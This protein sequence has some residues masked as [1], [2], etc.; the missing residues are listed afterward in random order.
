MPKQNLTDDEFIEQM[1][2]GESPV[3]P[4]PTRSEQALRAYMEAANPRVSVRQEPLGPG[5]VGA[6]RS[7]SPDEI[8]LSSKMKQGPGKTEEVLLHEMEHSLS[9]RGGNPLGAASKFTSAPVTTDNN[10]RFDLLYNMGDKKIENPSVKDIRRISEAGEG[11]KKRLTMI[12]NFVNN[13]RSLEQ[14][15][16]RPID[17]AYFNPN[18]LKAQVRYGTEGALFAEQIAD[19]SA[20]EQLT[21][22]SLTRDKEMKKLLFPDDRSAQIYDA[23]TG[24]RQTRLDSKD[25]P[26]YTPVSPEEPGML[27]RLKSLFGMQEGGEVSNEDFI[28]QMTVGTR[29][30]D[31]EADPNVVKDIVR[32]VQYTPFDVLG[33]PVDIAT[34]VMRP[35]GYNVEKPFGGSDYFIEQAAKRGLVQPATGSGAELL[36]RIA[37]GVTTPAVARG[38]GKVAEKTEDFVSKQLGAAAEKVEERSLAKLREQTGNPN[39]SAK[40]V[41]DAMFAAQAPGVPVVKPKGGNVIMENID[42]VDGRPVRSSPIEKMRPTVTV[43]GDRKPEILFASEFAARLKEQIARNQQDG[44]PTGYMRRLLDE[45]EPKAALDNWIQTKMSKYIRTDMGSE[46]DP[47]RKLAEEMSTKVKADYEA[48][49]KRIGKMKD[50]IAKA[51]AAGKNTDASEAELAEEIDKVENAYRQTS[52]LPVSIGPYTHPSS[53]N[54]RARAKAGFPEEPISKSSLAKEWEEVADRQFYLHRA[55]DLVEADSPAFRANPW[56]ANINPNEIVYDA[57]YVDEMHMFTHTL[58]E[59]EN[60]LRPGSGLPPRLQLK[61]EDMQ[62]LG[63]EKAF[64]LVNDINDWR[65]QQRTASNLEEANRAAVTVKQYPKSPGNLQWQELKPPTYTELPPGYAIEQLDYNTAALKGPD[66][67]ALT[68]FDDIASGNRDVQKEALSFLSKNDL[69]RAL[70][71]EGSTMRHCVGGYCND[72]WSGNTRIYSLRDSKGEPHV[73]IETAPANTGRL[74]PMAFYQNL[75]PESLITKMREARAADPTIS[76]DQMTELIRN[77]DE[78]KSYLTPSPDR[79]LQIKG[80]ANQKPTEKYIPFVQDFVA[81]QPWFEIGDLGNTDLVSLKPMLLKSAQERGFNPKVFTAVGD[82]T[83]V[84]KEEFNRLSELFGGMNKY[85]AGG[86]VTKFIRAHA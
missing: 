66:G 27:D 6:V 22:K 41:Y 9:L 23:I 65:F 2:A 63:I 57:P 70:K 60:A 33:A 62:Q 8:L 83:Y 69:E 71:Y 79:I 17:S 19:L 68:Y 80:K 25:L 58:D 53:T 82:L 40:E 12:Q 35:F 56:L 48:G 54:V 15:F 10:Y 4:S 85:A 21:G 49:L 64:R 20:L 47:V 81:S 76:P 78:Y 1:T 30:T 61:P 86:E 37:G 31:Q 18:M 36:G 38:V 45:V 34:M 29:P 32:G 75:A 13:R 42:M 59:L 3:E 39:L 55:G 73:T 51:Q 28:E 11:E 77:S 14:F 52:M 24:Y 72:V 5:V 26:P 84:T 7:S 44:N 67:K 46:A 16:G 74:E 50:N 43:P